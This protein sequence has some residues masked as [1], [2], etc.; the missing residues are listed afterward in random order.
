MRPIRKGAVCLTALAL[1]AGCSGGA[2][3]GMPKDAVAGKPPE[4]LT[5][6]MKQLAKANKTKRPGPTHPGLG[7]LP[8]HN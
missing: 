8:K 2:E 1:V 6:Q 5:D 4:A 7:P 3:E